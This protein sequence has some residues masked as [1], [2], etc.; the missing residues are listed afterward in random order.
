MKRIIVLL[1]ILLMTGCSFKADL[2]INESAQSKIESSSEVETSMKIK[3]L[4]EE[5][6]INLENNETVSE[7]VNMLPLDLELNELNGNEKYVYLDSNLPTNSVNVKHINKGDVMLF[8]NNCL[9]IFYESFDTPYSYTKIGHIDN[10][11][12]L[13]SED[14]SV[15]LT[16]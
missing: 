12:D 16:K 8:G 3:I 4:E 5:Y 11:P 14:I 9:V 6:T 2:T 1:L 13:G 15:Y 7:L 10:L